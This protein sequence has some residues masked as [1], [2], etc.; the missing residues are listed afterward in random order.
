MYSIIYCFVNDD[1]KKIKH[2]D[3]K[4]F[5]K[6]RRRLSLIA[7]V[8]ADSLAWHQ[9]V[10]DIQLEKMNESI[11]YDILTHVFAHFGGSIFDMIQ[12]LF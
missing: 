10:V 1:F 9:I 3:L 12:L 11:R 7:F 4:P 8:W 2:I 5:C 6:F